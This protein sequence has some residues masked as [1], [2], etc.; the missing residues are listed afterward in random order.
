MCS[1]GAL[2][3][4]KTASAA[5]KA[6]G[7]FQS[8]SAISAAA[9]SNIQEITRAF[10]Q[11]VQDIVAQ[12]QDARSD[13]VAGL[14]TVIARVK[15]A[16]VESGFTGKLAKRLKQ[17]ASATAQKDLSSLRKQKERAIRNVNTALFKSV[18]E[19]NEIIRRAD[20]AKK[21]QLFSS[22]LQIGVA[23]AQFKS[24]TDVLA[25]RE[26]ELESL[27]SFKQPTLGK[28]APVSTITGISTGL[29]IQTI[30]RTPKRRG[31]G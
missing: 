12:T 24:Q 30:Q 26:D 19:Q 20:A 11:N 8:A 27:R 2:F 23:G 1:P 14:D 6:I 22:V 7:T 16:T 25:A 28:T 9:G 10:N 15:V 5:S 3:A 17:S 29:K 18:G 31:D 13:I 4:L 21:Q